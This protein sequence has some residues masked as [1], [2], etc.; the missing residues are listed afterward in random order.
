MHQA[1]SHCDGQV[2]RGAAVHVRG[3]RSGHLERPFFQVLHLHTF[4]PDTALVTRHA[5]AQIPL[6]TALQLHMEK[7][8]CSTLSLVAASWRRSL[9]GICNQS[10]VKS[11]GVRCTGNLMARGTLK[12]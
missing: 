10:V 8:N 5:H 4:R 2:Q 11:R 6:T 12:A 3:A 9:F 1:A 7:V